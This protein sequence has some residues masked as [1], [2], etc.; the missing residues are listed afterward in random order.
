[1]RLQ[2]PHQVAKASMKDQLILFLEAPALPRYR[3]RIRCPGQRSPKGTEKQEEQGVMG[4][5]IR[6]DQE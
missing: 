6:N 5:Y 4:L 2:G 1:M 3:E